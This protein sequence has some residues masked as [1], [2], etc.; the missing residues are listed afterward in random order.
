MGDN[1][2]NIEKIYDFLKNIEDKE[3]KE[4]Y[5]KIILVLLEK[6]YFHGLAGI[7]VVKSRVSNID[8]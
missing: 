5:L 6:G 8:G 3:L 1:S 2:R 7:P 4:K